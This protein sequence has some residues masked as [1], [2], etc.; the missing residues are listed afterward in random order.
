VKI[1]GKECTIERAYELLTRSRSFD[2]KIEATPEERERLITYATLKSHN[3]YLRALEA[4]R[5]GY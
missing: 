4:A 1:D 5:R 3:D 2:D